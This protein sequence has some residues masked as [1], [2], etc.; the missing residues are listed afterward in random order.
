MS[1]VFMASL[2]RGVSVQSTVELILFWV[3]TMLIRKGSFPDQHFGYS[4]HVPHENKA[5]PC[6]GRTIVILHHGS[7]HRD[8]LKLIIFTEQDLLVYRRRRCIGRSWIIRTR[9]RDTKNKVTNPSLWANQ[10]PKFYSYSDFGFGSL[11]FKHPRFC[12]GKRWIQD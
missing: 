9:I 5:E 3:F 12:S 6:S 1:S 2:F 11:I 10:R 4:Q 7:R 8:N